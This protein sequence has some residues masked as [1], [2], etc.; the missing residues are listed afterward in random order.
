MTPYAVGR[1]PPVA[2]AAPRARSIRLPESA[3]LFAAFAAIAVW[4]ALVNLPTFGREDADDG[5]FLEAARLWTEGLPPYVATYDVKGP[6]GFAF[7]AAA[8][9]L[10]GPTLSTLKV[11]SI[12]A[13]SLAA[14]A[15][16]RIVQR[17]DRAAAVACVALYPVLMV[18]C[19][20]VVYQTMNAT[21][22][23]AFALAFAEPLDRRRAA[24]AGLAIGLA[25]AIKQTCALDALAA[26]YVLW[27][28]DAPRAERR[29][30][31][32][33]FAFALPIAP[34]GFFLYYACRGDAGVFLAD[35]VFAALR[36]NP[37][38]PFAAALRAWAECLF[39]IAPAL[40][41]AAAAQPRA[42]EIEAR[43][44]LRAVA[45]WLGLELAG[46]AAQ[47]AGCSVYVT[48][49]VAPALIIAAIAVSARFGA[50]RPRRRAA[51]LVAFAAAVLWTAMAGR[52]AAV[53]AKTPALDYALL[54]QIKA[55]VDATGPRPDDRLLTINGS[56][57]ANIVADLRPPTPYFHWAHIL[58]DFPGAG[59]P[60]LAA[61][62]AAKPRY[63]VF[64]NP[65]RRPTCEPAAYANAIDAALAAG[66]A[67]AAE[68]RTPQSRF[69]LFERAR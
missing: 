21:L 43:F 31:L 34:A 41:V 35:V 8:A 48:P 61:D 62:L 3:R 46:L 56:A 53:L 9:A 4:T 54:D 58:C 2:A 64:E 17:Y 69:R 55:A 42:A 1:T 29:R 45:V 5:F 12:A 26:A 60:A 59:L 65:D 38:A 44:P 10:L 68:G 16:Y 6:A 30:A 19:G 13:S 24:A 63:V 36:R 7:L 67:L 18:V 14:T 22:L 47:K 15:L 37:D 57:F 23:V 50:E 28:K 39:P 52:G 32:A 11:L 49:L 25:C 66:Y 40:I 20:D 27:A 51:A 33:A